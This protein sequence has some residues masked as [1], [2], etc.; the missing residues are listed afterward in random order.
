[1]TTAVEPS[2]SDRE[3][4]SRRLNLLCI[5]NSLTDQPLRDAIVAEME[6]ADRLHRRLVAV[7]AEADGWA[8]VL[9]NS[10]RLY[11]Q[12]FAAERGKLREAAAWIIRIGYPHDWT[13]HEHPPAA[14]WEA[15]VDAV[16]DDPT[17]TLHGGELS[18]EEAEAWM[19]VETGRPEDEQTEMEPS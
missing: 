5:A 12:H 17:G 18:R 6:A 1:M 11:D 9:R 19:R 14:V 16:H 4:L 13:G 3:H 15:L 7:R 8:E 2:E 10:E